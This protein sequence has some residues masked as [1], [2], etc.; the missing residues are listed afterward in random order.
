M[1]KFVKNFLRD[2]SGGTAVEYGLIA[3]LVSVGAASALTL[4]CGPG[5]H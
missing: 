3:G 4:V 1:V 2:E 5:F